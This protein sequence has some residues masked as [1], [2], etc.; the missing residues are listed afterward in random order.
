MSG[1]AVRC[2]LQER[3]REPC[4][5]RG[6]W[7]PERWLAFMIEHKGP[8]IVEQGPQNRVGFAQFPAD[9]INGTFEQLLSFLWYSLAVE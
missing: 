1:S 3:N 4:L 2:P 6:R 7:F 5:L 9:G 8:E